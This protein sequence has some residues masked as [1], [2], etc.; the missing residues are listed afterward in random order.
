PPPVR[1]V[2]LEHVGRLD[3]V[4]VDADE[5]EVVH[6]HD[7]ML[8]RR[9]PFMTIDDSSAGTF[10]LGD[11]TVRRL[12]FGAMRITGEGIWGEPP[13]H[14]EAVRVVRRAVE[15]GVNLIDTADSYGPEVSE[16]IIAEALRP[17]PDDL[18]IATK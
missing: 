9:L 10:T 11:K 1:E 4:V 7:P 2:A 3:D 18:L 14:D 5:D 15:L 13:D 8:A 6:A 17:Y 16:N 12:G